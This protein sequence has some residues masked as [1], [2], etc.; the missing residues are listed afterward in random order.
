MNF[1]T[2][3]NNIINDRIIDAHIHVF[4][5]NGRTPL[6][7]NIKKIGFMDIW[8]PELSKYESRGS[9]ELYKNFISEGLPPHTTLLAT[10][11]DPDQIIHIYEDNKPY[12]KGFGELKCYDYSF[13]KDTP[14]KLDFKDLSWVEDVCKYN[15]ENLPI[16]IHYSLDWTNYKILEELFKKYSHIPFVLC[17]CGIGTDNEYGF[18]LR[19]EP[20]E[21][22]K[23]ACV[24]AR[25]DNVYLEISYTAATWLHN[26]PPA[27]F[28]S[29]L[30]SIHPSKFLLGTDCNNFQFYKD[31]EYGS[32]LYNKKQQKYFLDLYK[33]FGNYNYINIR[34]LFG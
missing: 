5:A 9:E 4:D 20:L 27:I 26:C 10:A 16:Y 3:S 8:F 6:N 25:L 23:L 29:L 12:I 31:F 28:C 13:G 19:G 33:Y 15:I 14:V 11:P 30:Y 17:H 7:N 32:E 1:S 18:S 21:S 24:L 22:F 34:K 2:Y